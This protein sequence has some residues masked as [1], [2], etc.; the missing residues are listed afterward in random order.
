MRKNF[1]GLFTDSL[2][3]FVKVNNLVLEINAVPG[4]AH[5][6]PDSQRTHKC[7]VY[8]QMEQFVVDIGEGLRYHIVF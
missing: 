5:R 2:Q 1:Q 3:C 7:E 4:K 6:F 8:R